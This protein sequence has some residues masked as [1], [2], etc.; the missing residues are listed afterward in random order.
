MSLKNTKIE[1][2]LRVPFQSMDRRV[3]CNGETKLLTCDLYQFD[4]DSEIFNYFQDNAKSKF[5][6]PCRVSVVK[7]ARS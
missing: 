7:G 6:K 5:G 1:L 4:L 2:C 3:L